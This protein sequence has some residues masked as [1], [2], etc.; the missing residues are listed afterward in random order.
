MCG[1][2]G[3]IAG[4]NSGLNE[5][6][7]KQ[8]FEIIAKLSLSRGSDSAGVSVCNLQKKVFEIVKGDIP[9]HDLLKSKEYK[10]RITEA[11]ISYQK[12]NVFN[13]MGHARL[14]TNGSQ[15]APENN[16]PVVKDK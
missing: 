9:I 12:G 2:F 5:K 15:L 16:Q 11:L 10:K 6:K 14:V 1:I 8:C 3:V 7:V 13:A 4:P